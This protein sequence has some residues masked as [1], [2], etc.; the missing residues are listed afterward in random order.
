VIVIPHSL[1]QMHSWLSGRDVIPQAG[2]AVGQ[3]LRPAMVMLIE[4]GLIGATLAGWRAQSAA[5]PAARRAAA[6]AAL[7]SPA[8]TNTGLGE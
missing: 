5:G 1:P 3:I 7:C 4:F 6:K 2:Y 8:A